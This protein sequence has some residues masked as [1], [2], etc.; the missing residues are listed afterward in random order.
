[1]TREPRATPANTRKNNNRKKKRARKRNKKLKRHV[2]TTAQLQHHHLQ[3]AA[4][5]A[6]HQQQ[7]MMLYHTPPVNIRAAASTQQPFGSPSIEGAQPSSSSSSSPPQPMSVPM[8][9][10]NQE[11]HHE[12]QP[13]DDAPLQQHGPPIPQPRYAS[14]G[15]VSDASQNAGALTPSPQQQFLPA[16]ISVPALS[17][18]DHYALY[19]HHQQQHHN[20]LVA[21]MHTAAQL[22]RESS[23]A[24]PPRPPQKATRGPSPSK[25]KRKLRK[26]L[27]FYFSDKNLAGDFFLKSL[28]DDRGAV[29]LTDIARFPR[30][31]HLLGVANAPL[32]SDHSVSMLQNAVK[33]SRRLQ[34]FSNDQCLGRRPQL[35]Q[36]DS[37]NS[38]H[39]ADSSPESH[40]FI[41]EAFVPIGADENEEK[42]EP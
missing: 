24:P 22:Q 19:M 18:R 3:L 40:H 32:G 7:L 21:M 12:Q 23:R 35:P 25:L 26:Q 5:A 14:L 6:F 20:A 15:I 38:H 4:A 9:S 33:S 27:E 8:D 41:E 11:N 36:N 17:P 1:M 39:H 31:Q 42:G 2:A 37:S 34:L 28:M 29:S 30:V 16:G 10:L 13:S